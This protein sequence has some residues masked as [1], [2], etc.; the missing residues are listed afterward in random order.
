MS[1]NADALFCRRTL[2]GFALGALTGRVCVADEAQELPVSLKVLWGSRE[3]VAKAHRPE[4]WIQLRLATLG[5]PNAG[6]N[7]GWIEVPVEKGEVYAT[8]M[9]GRRIDAVLVR[10]KD[11]VIVTLTGFAIGPTPV[12]VHLPNRPGEKEVLQLTRYPA[13]NNVFVAI[14]VG[15]HPEPLKN[16]PPPTPPKSGA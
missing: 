6:Q 4:R 7:T 15:R 1:L 9:G 5:V 8:M 13:P 14:E 11:E 2:M 12:T 10:G 3:A 16:P